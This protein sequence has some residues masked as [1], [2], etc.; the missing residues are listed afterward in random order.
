MASKREIK[1]DVNY[2]TNEVLVDGIMMMSL[3]ENKQDEIMGKLEQVAAARNQFVEAVQHPENKFKR[4]PREERGKTRAAR[5]KAFK[6]VVNTRFDAFASA[7]DS[8]YEFLGTL[9]EE[10]K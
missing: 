10:K 3:Y 4:M 7:L 2:L 1:N 8:A 9:A 5:T 6:K